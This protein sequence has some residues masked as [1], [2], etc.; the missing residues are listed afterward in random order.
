MLRIASHALKTDIKDLRLK[1]GA[2]HAEKHPGH[3]LSFKEIASLAYK[4][5]TLLPDDLEPGLKE[6]AYYQNP[7]AKFPR[8]EDFTVQLTHANSLHVATVEVDELTGVVTFLKYVVV[9]DCGNLI[10]PAIVDG[11]TIGSTVHGIGAILLEEFVYDDNGQLLN[12]TFMDYLKPVALGLPR[13]EIGH[14]HSPRPNT[15]LGTKSAGEGGAIGFLAAVANAVE[16]ALAPFDVKVRSLPITPEKVVRAI[17]ETKEIQFAVSPPGI[18]RV[19]L[20]R[21]QL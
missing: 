10:N 5:V 19:E 14:M 21:N 20:T 17:T 15:L 12:T 3:S 9:H 4:R 18:N 11:M 1:D 16:D 6:I 13:F 8:K 2:V 7:A